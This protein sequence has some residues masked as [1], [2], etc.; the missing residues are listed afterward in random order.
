MAEAFAWI[1]YLIGAATVATA[2]LDHNAGRW[3]AVETAMTLVGAITWPLGAAILILS[4]LLRW[5]R[6]A[7]GT[8]PKG[9]K[10]S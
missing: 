4:R 8:K 2:P 1:L 9:V 10:R 7:A 3:P 5:A 6:G